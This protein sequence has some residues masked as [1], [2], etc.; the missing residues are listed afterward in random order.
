MADECELT[1]YTRLQIAHHLSTCLLV[2]LKRSSS[3]RE[4]VQ[5]EISLFL[6]FRF[7]WTIPLETF[8]DVFAI[9]G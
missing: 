9:A 2:T 3:A 6:S 1:F 8:L 7:D 4:P 5:G